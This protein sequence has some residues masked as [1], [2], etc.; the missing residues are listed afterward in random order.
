MCMYVCIYVCKHVMCVCVCISVQPSEYIIYLYIYKTFQIE[1]I[2]FTNY[3][4]RIAEQKNS[5][6][7]CCS[8]HVFP[9]LLCDFFLFYRFLPKRATIIVFSFFFFFFCIFKFYYLRCIKY[10]FGERNRWERRREYRL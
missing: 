6:Q 2:I 10:F 7:V 4:N 9:P 8:S 1:I 3:I 5:R